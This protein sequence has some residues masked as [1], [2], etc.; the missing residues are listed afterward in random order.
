MHKHM[1][2]LSLA[3]TKVCYSSIL[4]LSELHL[5][6]LHGKNTRV[7]V[8]P[9][10][11]PILHVKSQIL[12]IIRLLWGEW[13]FKDICLCLCVCVFCV[14]EGGGGRWVRMQFRSALFGSASVNIFLFLHLHHSPASSLQR[15]P[16]SILWF[17]SHTPSLS[18]PLVAVPLSVFPSTTPPALSH[19]KSHTYVVENGELR[20]GLEFRFGVFW[21]IIDG[22]QWDAAHSRGLGSIHPPIQWIMSETAICLLGTEHLVLIIS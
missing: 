3:S 22:K 18:S 5:F 20:G 9:E 11:K 17:P 4:V 1:H 7:P 21:R 8:Q 13:E 2:T 19:S 14:C 12:E 10:N 6:I 15:S 16:M